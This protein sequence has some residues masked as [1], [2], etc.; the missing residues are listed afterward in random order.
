MLGLKKTTLN[1]EK[2]IKIIFTHN[3][4]KQVF[5]SINVNNVTIKRVNHLIFL[6]IRLYDSLF[7]FLPPNGKSER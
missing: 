3:N 4:N 1:I 7:G 5:A 2:S 6:G